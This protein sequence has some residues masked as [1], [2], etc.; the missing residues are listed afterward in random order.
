MSQAW[1]AI[2]PAGSINPGNRMS[3]HGGFGLYLHGPM[4]FAEALKGLEGHAEVVFTY[5]VLFEEGFE[6][7][8]GGKLPGI[9][10]SLFISVC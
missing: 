3:P 1:E 6:F 4:R 5:S 10:E 8:K 9:C 2:F 7:V